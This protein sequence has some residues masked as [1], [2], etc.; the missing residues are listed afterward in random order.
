MACAPLNISAVR[1]IADR[2]EG[3]GSADILSVCQALGSMTVCA[4]FCQALEQD[5][6]WN[7]YVTQIATDT[8][9]PGG[10]LTAWMVL[11][12]ARDQCSTSILSG[13]GGRPNWAA[14]EPLERPYQYASLCACAWPDEL[15]VG[16]L[17][18]HPGAR[19]ASRL[20]YTSLARPTP[21][22]PHRP[23]AGQVVLLCA[24]FRWHILPARHRRPRQSQR[25]RPRRW[26]VRA[27]RRRLRAFLPQ[28]P[29]GRGERTVRSAAAATGVLRQ[30]GSRR[31]PF[32]G[33]AL[34]RSARRRS[35]RRM[36]PA[37]RTP[38]PTSHLPA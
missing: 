27:P 15:P 24:P 13:G 16:F 19:V 28:P 4:S 31:V 5:K 3:S 17:A 6:C 22:L 35:R 34:H 20:V 36:R 25:R 30:G 12:A 32:R 10:T 38:S 9:N 21:P 29:T 7:H 1:S 18:M 14:I 8:A 23:R 2:V 33:A 37:A 11:Q 26:C